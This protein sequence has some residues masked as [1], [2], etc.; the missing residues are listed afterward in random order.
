MNKF[1]EGIIFFYFTVRK[2]WSRDS[3]VGVAIGYGLD[4][5]GVAFRVPVGSRI[6]SSPRRQDRLWSPPN[7]LPNGYRG[8]FP[9]G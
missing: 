5:R 8:F 2:V 7:L 6:F 4:D 1:S 3:T 9:R